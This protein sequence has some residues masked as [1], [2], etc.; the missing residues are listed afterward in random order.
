MTPPT[1]ESGSNAPE[2]TLSH[3]G[4]Q[5]NQSNGDY[6]STARTLSYKKA[7][8]YIPKQISNLGADHLRISHD[9]SRGC[10]CTYPRATSLGVHKH[11]PTGF[12]GWLQFMLNTLTR[13]RS[14]T[15]SD[16]FSL[17]SF[18][19]SGQ[20]VSLAYSVGDES[21]HLLECSVAS[22]G[23]LLSVYRAQIYSWYIQFNKWR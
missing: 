1:G 16:G 10:T 21:A 19:L 3:N 12:L 14:Y 22:S 17:V 7:L 2:R 18:S 23:L 4:D 9:E 20:S 11:S 8:R 15:A 5:S 6:L 13:T